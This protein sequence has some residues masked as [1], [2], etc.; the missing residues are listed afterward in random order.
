MQNECI[1]KMLYP[2]Y[3]LSPVA[4][5]SQRAKAV[6]LPFPGGYPSTPLT[7]SCKRGDAFMMDP[8]GADALILDRALVA[9]SLR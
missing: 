7:F 5:G 3:G 4:Y 8:A 2:L 9:S 1:D 6:T